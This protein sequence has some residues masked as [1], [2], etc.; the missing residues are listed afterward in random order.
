MKELEEKA[1]EAFS[2]MHRYGHEIKF[3]HFVV[4]AYYAAILLL[5]TSAWRSY[6]SVDQKDR[7]YIGKKIYGIP[8]TQ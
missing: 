8:V 6:E 5:L 4:C 3:S 2:R 1:G 7:A